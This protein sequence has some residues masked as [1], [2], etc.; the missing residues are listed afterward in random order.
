MHGTL[1]VI[2]FRHA[3]LMRTG[4]DRLLKMGYKVRIGLMVRD[5]GA[6][7]SK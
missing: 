3:Y 6:A 4:R 1:R 2:P 7:T 5:S